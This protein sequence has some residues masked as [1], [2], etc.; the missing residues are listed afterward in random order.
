M[1]IANSYNATHWLLMLLLALSALQANAQPTSIT[2]DFSQLKIEA[3]GRPVAK[4]SGNMLPMEASRLL[5]G[6]RFPT[7]RLNKGSKGRF[8]GHSEPS[9]TLTFKGQLISWANINPAGELP[10]WLGGR[11]LPQL[12]Y[13]LNL[14]KNHLFDVEAS[15][16]LFG[17][18][19]FR[20]FD[21]AAADGDIRPYRLW[22]RYSA[23]QFEFRLGL[24]KINFGSASLLRPLMWFDQIDPRDPIQFTDG[25]WAALGR[26]YFLNNANVWVWG[27]YGNKD[28][29]GWEIAGTSKGQPEFG[30]RVQYPIPHGEAG[31]SYHHRQ[32]DTRGL[33]NS[34]PAFA[35]ASEN[36]FGVDVKLDLAVGCWVEASWATNS[37]ALEAFTNQELINVGIDYTFGIGNG[38]YAVV[39]QLL[40]S[41]GEEAFSFANTTNLS[42]VSLSYPIGLFDNLGAIVYIDWAN[43]KLYNFITWTIQFDRTALY[44]MG[45]W[46]PKDNQ[47]PTQNSTRNLY[48]G[49][50]VQVLF[51]FNH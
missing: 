35:R 11:Y 39:E 44:V 25:V 20:P 7:S 46:N 8:T 16:N 15:A 36:R 40:A 43:G 31:F 5:S 38:L 3:P 47:I 49:V 13:G 28:P 42:L 34:I 30:G 32:A 51:L 22:A 26:Y 2:K 37:K 4:A 33:N 48:S 10:A 24:Q 6:F 17:N 12:N 41:Y 21:T 9:D 23:P 27:L 50:G 14:P 45:Y 18:V 29:K 19:G 1:K